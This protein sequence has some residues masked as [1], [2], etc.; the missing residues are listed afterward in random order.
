MTMAIGP[1][2]LLIHA[3]AGWMQ[4]E[5]TKL[6]DY[7]LAEIAVLRA[8]LPA[9]RLVF[10]GAERRRLAARGYA[11]GRAALSAIVT[12]VTPD[13]I[14][15]WHHQL[16]AAKST[17]QKSG[18]PGRPGLMKSIAELIVRFAKEN[19]LFNSQRNHQALGNKLIAPVAPVGSA[20]GR[21]V[22][23]ESLGG[24]LNFYSRRAA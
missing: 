21:L 4:R 11:L 17:T 12:I 7:L 16:I 1:L 6:I 10:T 20:D 24:V 22:R 15:R 5:Q 18:R 13:T 19:P 23:E 9:K 3:V 8:R 14:L 2:H